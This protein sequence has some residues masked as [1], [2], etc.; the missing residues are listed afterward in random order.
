MRRLPFEAQIRS[1]LNEL[2]VRLM[3]SRDAVATPAAPAAV[4]R[5]SG[6]RGLSGLLLLLSG[7]G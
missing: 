7:L 2:S 3:E 5:T 6:V 1:T 4:E